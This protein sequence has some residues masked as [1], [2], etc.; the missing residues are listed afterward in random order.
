MS[1]SIQIIHAKQNPCACFLRRG[2]TGTPLSLHDFFRKK[3]EH[4]ANSFPA[5]GCWTVWQPADYG[6]RMISQAEISAYA[7]RCCARYLGGFQHFHRR[8]TTALLAGVH[9]SAC[10][11]QHNSRVT[12]P[13][14]A[15]ELQRTGLDNRPAVPRLRSVR[16]L[17]KTR[18]KS[19]GHC[20]TLND[21]RI[22]VGIFVPGGGIGSSSR[23]GLASGRAHSPASSC[24]CG[25][26]NHWAE[27]QAILFDRADR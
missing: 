11:L 8:V 9:A 1:V 25:S 5:A 2:D 4:V 24:P 23:T 21:R 18:L 10:G 14:F 27:V 6:P 15:A 13:T 19:L 17:Q 16:F 7:N 3:R 22:S 26:S 20:A 12:I